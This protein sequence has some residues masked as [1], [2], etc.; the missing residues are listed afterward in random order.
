MHI[1]MNNYK[2]HRF[3]WISCTFLDFEPEK[4]SW[5]KWNAFNSLHIRDMVFIWF[6]FILCHRRHCCTPAHHLHYKYF[7]HVIRFC[8]FFCRSSWVHQNTA[9]GVTCDLETSSLLLSLSLSNTLRLLSFTHYI[10]FR[11]K[12][13]F[14]NSAQHATDAVSPQ[15][16]MTSHLGTRMLTRAFYSVH[17]HKSRYSPLVRIS[18]GMWREDFCAQ[19][20]RYATQVSELNWKK[21]PTSIEFQ[22]KK[23]ITPDKSNESK[24]KKWVRE[25]VVA[26]VRQFQILFKCLIDC[27]YL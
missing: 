3:Q 26:H 13:Q 24:R 6:S 11:L 8:F 27:F 20:I 5:I 15:T 14:L 23:T 16:T 2:Y 21:N 10:R 12:K 7:L 22:N 17:H 1:R 19:V 4:K 25:T 18:S 9:S